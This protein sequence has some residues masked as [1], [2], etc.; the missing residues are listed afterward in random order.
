MTW[1]LFGAGTF[2]TIVMEN[3][4]QLILNV[5]GLVQERR[6]SSVLAMELRLSCTDPSMYPNVM[7]TPNCHQNIHESRDVIYEYEI[8]VIFIS[9]FLCGTYYGMAQIKKN[10]QALCHRPLWGES[11][12]HW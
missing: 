6:N 8:W 12:S 11:T 5:N 4:S 10:I 3:A 9:S 1:S 7:K 2:A